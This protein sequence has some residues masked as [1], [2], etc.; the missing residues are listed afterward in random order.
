MEASP[1]LEE[2]VVGQLCHSQQ[3]RFLPTL[4]STVVTTPRP[5]INASPIPTTQRI[6]VE[7]RCAGVRD[8]SL[9]NS[10]LLLPA[11]LRPASLVR[12]RPA[13]VVTAPGRRCKYTFRR[14]LT[15]AMITADRA[16]PTRVPVTPKR[17]VRAAPAGEAIPTA[18][19]LGR[20]RRCWFSCLSTKTPSSL[21]QKKN[22]GSFLLEPF[23]RVFLSSWGVLGLPFV[24][25]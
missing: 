6:R 5:M 15:T 11:D 19:I 20:S 25:S 10:D 24:L 3:E 16:S 17:E 22:R 1:S 14:S 12:D 8:A 21:V 18:I 2:E 4:A 23:R 13:M 9:E 7:R